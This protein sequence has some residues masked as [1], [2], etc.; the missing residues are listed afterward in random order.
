MLKTSNVKRS[1]LFQFS[2]ARCKK[3]L[4]RNRP[5]FI[6]E[7]KSEMIFSFVNTEALLI[8]NSTTAKMAES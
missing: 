4:S 1:F 7:A 6:S 2:I 8:L 5:F 3:W